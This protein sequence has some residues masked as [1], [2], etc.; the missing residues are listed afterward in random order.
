MSS[1]NAQTVPIDSNTT[2]I[3]NPV[4]NAIS[5]LF[6]FSS[7]KGNIHEAIISPKRT[8]KKLREMLTEY[9]F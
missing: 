3:V 9:S 6:D 7:I 8:L 5:K 2:K 4:R 1:L